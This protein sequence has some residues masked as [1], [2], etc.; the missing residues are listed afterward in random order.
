MNS[1]FEW[2]KHQVNERVQKY[3]QEAA[4]HRQ[5]QEV[6]GRKPDNLL[7]VLA[8]L[9]GVFFMMWLTVGCTSHVSM[10]ADAPEPQSSGW[11]MA[12]RVDFQDKREAYLGETTA[13]GKDAGWTMAQRIQFQ[14]RREA[15]LDWRS[16]TAHVTGM[17][18]DTR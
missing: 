9:A 14:D 5:V 12:D 18:M 7:L 2:Q 13:V 16:G 6:N 8:M 10:A 15:Y 17:T 4:A 1:N 11:V 3:Q